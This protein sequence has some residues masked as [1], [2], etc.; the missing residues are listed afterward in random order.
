[1]FRRISSLPWSMQVN[2]RGMIIEE[3][4]DKIDFFEVKRF[5]SA[6]A[7]VK[8]MTRQMTAYIYKTYI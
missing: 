4:I 8:K 1:M 6:T 3:K 5:S 2:K 7:T